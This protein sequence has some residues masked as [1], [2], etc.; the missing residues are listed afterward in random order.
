[1]EIINFTLF[2][3]HIV[4]KSIGFATLQK[5]LLKHLTVDSSRNNVAR[6]N[7]F[8]TFSKQQLLKHST[9]DKFEDNVA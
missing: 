5:L 8:T 6:T 1:M 7:S 9:V 3:K 2:A 4:T